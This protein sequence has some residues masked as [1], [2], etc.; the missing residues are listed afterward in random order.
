MYEIIEEDEAL[1]VVQLGIMRKTKE[2]EVKSG[3]MTAERPAESARNRDGMYNRNSLWSED[4]YFL[5]SMCVC[6]LSYML[7]IKS[8]SIQ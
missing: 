1:C 6:L 5:L 8:I 2:Y 4:E 3:I 7:R